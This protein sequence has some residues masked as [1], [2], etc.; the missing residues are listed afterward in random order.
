[1]HW[2]SSGMIGD[3][4]ANLL[5][6]AEPHPFTEISQLVFFSSQPRN[7]DNSGNNP[8]V[9]S[10][11]RTSNKRSKVRG[12]SRCW[13]QHSFLKRFATSL[14]PIDGFKSSFFPV[15]EKFEVKILT[16]SRFSSEFAIW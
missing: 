6:V 13:S 11:V 4:K 5:E 9:F 10:V 15:T 12:V 1:M 16:I 7:D 8:C 3:T 14:K 2:S